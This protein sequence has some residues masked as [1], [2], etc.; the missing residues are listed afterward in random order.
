MVTAGLVFCL[1]FK[2][3]NS[4]PIRPTALFNSLRERG[5]SKNAAWTKTVGLRF[6]TLRSTN[7]CSPALYHKNC[8]VANTRSIYSTQ[9]LSHLMKTKDNMISYHPFTD[10][11]GEKFLQQF[12]FTLVPVSPISQT[13]SKESKHC[14]RDQR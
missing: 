14:T 7:C 11:V 3:E 8:A 6:M 12:S 13:I 5:L 2:T 4:S 9:R 10:K 1:S